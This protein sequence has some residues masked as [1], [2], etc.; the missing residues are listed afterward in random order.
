MKPSNESVESLDE[1]LPNDFAT[2]P[3]DGS[4]NGALK[5]LQHHVDVISKNIKAGK[6]VYK[7]DLMKMANIIKSLQKFEGV[8]EYNVNKKFGS[9]YDIGAGSM[10]NGTTFWNRAEEE[11]GEYKK[12]AHVSDNGMVKFYDKSL[13]SNVKKHIEDYAKT[14]TESVN[15]AKAG[16][17]EIG[18]FIHFKSKNKTGMVKKISG[19]KVT[20]MTMSGD[21][22]GDM[23]DIQVLYQDNVNEGQLNEWRA[24]EVLQ[25]LGGRRFIAMT[26]AKNFVKNDKDKSIVFRVPKAKNSINTI[27][28]TLTSMDL[29][30]VEFISVRGTNIKTVATEKGVYND[31]LQAIFTKYTGLYTSL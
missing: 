9:K 27:R 16:D 2:I 5:H 28:I 11:F 10:G 21:V 14:Q 13:P 18:D 1:K 31:Q 3:N 29:Y 23:K 24:E 12:L 22:T 15:E 30:N 7:K 20:I 26:G 8:N 25:Q 4:V 19:N 17:F 6:G